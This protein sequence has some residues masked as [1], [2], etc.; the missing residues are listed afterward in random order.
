MDID[1]P[2]EARAIERMN[3]VEGFINRIGF[4]P[5]PGLS[6]RYCEPCRFTGYSW[7]KVCPR[8]GGE[9]KEVE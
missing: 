1:S 3:K 6:S 7:Q 8:C 9:M 4:I 5:P 2:A